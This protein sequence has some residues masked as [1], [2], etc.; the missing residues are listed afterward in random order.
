[1]NV[2]NF[3]ITFLKIWSV[4][5]FKQL[6][7]TYINE[8]LNRIFFTF[9]KIYL[10]IFQYFIMHDRIRASCNETNVNLTRNIPYLRNFYFCIWY[11]LFSQMLY[12]EW[13]WFESWI[14]LILLTLTSTIS[15]GTEKVHY[16]SLW[17]N[18][19]V[20]WNFP[21]IYRVPIKK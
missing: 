19:L 1:M 14:Y 15:A 7:F 6:Y 13:V 9:T 4:P 12:K 18:A 11:I 8:L 3:V 20:V 10:I 17:S 5:Y 21:K 2:Y 16:G